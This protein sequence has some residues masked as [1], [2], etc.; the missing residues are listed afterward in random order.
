MSLGAGA[1]S[2]DRLIEGSFGK[3]LPMGYQPVPSRP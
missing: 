3:S 1:W 2:F